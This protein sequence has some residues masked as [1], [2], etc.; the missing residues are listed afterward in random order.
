MKT[1]LFISL[2]G[3][4]VALGALIIAIFSHHVFNKRFSGIN[5]KFLE[6]INV[7]EKLTMSVQTHKIDEFP[8]NIP[9]IIKLID[10]AE[11][12]IEIY[13]D[14]TCIGIYSKPEFGYAYK[15][16]LEKIKLDSKYGKVAVHIYT[17]N[18]DSTQHVMNLFFKSKKIED[19]KES[20][21][22]EFLKGKYPNKYD[23]FKKLKTIEDFINFMTE[24]EIEFKQ[25][26]NDNTYCETYK[27]VEINIHIPF[28]MWIIDDTK[29]IIDLPYY[30]YQ[31]NEESIQTSDK[32]L[33]DIFKNFL[34]GQIKEN[35][36]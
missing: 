20:P 27:N 22:A 10:S 16:L 13:S 3:A 21:Y 15:N 5:T 28:F 23:K 14:L 4:V 35:K 24:E 6:T 18:K 26:L 12:S 25:Q 1:E 19:I 30:H 32:A 17:Y 9:E 34:D 36:Q 33:I 11:K 2:L 8:K 31:A 29:A 7:I